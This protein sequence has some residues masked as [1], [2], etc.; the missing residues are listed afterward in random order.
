LTR[1][2]ILGDARSAALTLSN[3]DTPAT[4]SKPLARL[5][6]R[7]CSG[8]SQRLAVAL[9]ATAVLQDPAPHLLL[10]TL[11]QYG[12]LQRG[13]QAVKEATVKVGFGG[14]L[15]SSPGIKQK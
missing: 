14:V 9:D 12:L 13:W 1:D 2:A 10:P 8:R 3:S 5:L 15:L 4:S 6:S 11:L 7:I